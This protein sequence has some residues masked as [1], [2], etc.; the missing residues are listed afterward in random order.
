MPKFY[1]FGDSSNTSVRVFLSYLGAYFD[2][3]NK[4]PSLSSNKGLKEHKEKALAFQKNQCVYCKKT[5]EPHEKIEKDHIIPINKVSA[6]LHCWG[7]V[8]YCCSTCNR[9]KNTDLKQGITWQKHLE[10]NNAREIHNEWTK[11]YPSGE[12]YSDQLLKQCEEV[13][14][15][16]EKCMRTKI[17]LSKTIFETNKI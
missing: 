10:K 9:N 2:E 11:M 8:L 6:G 14:R 5:F 12:K 7:N 4:L 1:N 3:Q 16:I 17:N 15:E 13:Y